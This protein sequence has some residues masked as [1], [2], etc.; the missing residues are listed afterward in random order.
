VFFPNTATGVEVEAGEGPLLHVQ[1]AAI[2]EERGSSGLEE[3]SRNEEFGVQGCGE[4]NILDR[5]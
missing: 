2:K 5:F 3:V 4:Y 1:L